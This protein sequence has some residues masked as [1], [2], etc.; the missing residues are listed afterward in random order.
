N[1]QDCADVRSLT[2]ILG[3]VIDKHKLPMDKENRTEELIEVLLPILAYHGLQFRKAIID[4]QILKKFL[5]AEAVDDEYDMG[6]LRDAHDLNLMALADVDEESFSFQHSIYQEYFAAIHLAKNPSARMEVIG[7]PDSPPKRNKFWY[8]RWYNSLRLLMPLLSEPIQMKILEQ[9]SVV[10]PGELFMVALSGVKS[11][12]LRTIILD[13]VPAVVKAHP[14]KTA[15]QLKFLT[16][17]EPA[18]TVDHV[19]MGIADPRILPLTL[20]RRDERDVFDNKTAQMLEKHRWGRTFELNRIR[21]HL[22]KYPVTN[23]EFYEFVKAGGYNQEKGS[24]YWDSEQRGIAGSGEEEWFQKVQP[25]RPRYWAQARE[26]RNNLRQPNYPVVGITLYEAKAYCR[27][28]SDRDGEKLRYRLPQ[29]AEWTYVAYER[30]PQL[31]DIAMSVLPDCSEDHIVSHTLAVDSDEI[32]GIVEQIKAMSVKSGPVQ[33][34]MIHN[35]KS[36][37]SDL[38]GNIWEWCDTLLDTY[39]VYVRGGPRENWTSLQ[40]LLFDGVFTPGVRA[41]SVGFRVLREVDPENE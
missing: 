3:E 13:T 35:E 24:K 29:A 15:M 36:A 11:Q 32:D 10:D 23:L 40:S 30:W 26:N 39:R 5:V 25:E 16:L 19:E 37:C 18:D 34:G 17:C 28:L 4:R 7:N 1:D 38:F 12:L 41:P 20:S 21:Y 31:R 27:W 2:E 14:P 22:A 6:W 9:L 33:V 8:R